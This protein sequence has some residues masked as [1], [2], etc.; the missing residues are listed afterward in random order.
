M[1]P[2]MT[3]ELWRLAW[4][5]MLRNLLNCSC[6]RLTLAVVGHYDHN[7]AHYDGAGLG[8]MLSNITGLSV[9]LGINMG[10]STMCAQAYGAGRS[11]NENWLHLRR[12]CFFL[13]CVFVWSAATA[14]FADNILVAFGQP[15][16][17]AT[18]S[19]QFAQINLVGV[20]FF[21]LSSALQTICDGLQNTKPGL[22]SMAVASICQIGICVALVNPNVG[23]VGFLGMAMARSAA[24]VIQLVVLVVLIKMQHLA[25]MV[26]QRSSNR[27]DQV[28]VFDSEA[29]RAYVVVTLP[30]AIIWWLEWWSFEGLTV[31]VG[32]LPNAVVTL[33]AH[34]TMFNVI[35]TTY[36]IF[37][38][39]GIA[40]CAMTGKRIGQGR[41]NE[42]P[43]MCLLASALAVFFIAVVLCTLYFLR[44]Q[45]GQ[46]FSNNP[47]IIESVKRNM[48]GGCFSV[49]G[50]AFLMTLGGACRGA[51]RQRLVALSTLVG[52]GIGLPLAWVLG[53]HQHWPT[54]LF[55]VWIG[56]AA[57]LAFAA[58]CTVA[59]VSMIDW[60]TVTKAVPRMRS[61][62]GSGDVSGDGK[63][64]RLLSPLTTSDNEDDA[65]NRH[66]VNAHIYE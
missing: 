38:G 21:W 20:P 34:G 35:V 45:I 47:D 14:Y 37:Q 63:S 44:E 48:L 58:S 46:L 3:W 55:G 18:A 61:N 4:P 25:P 51:N 31:M 7:T 52:Y 24:G 17:V 60:S 57:A 50:Y 64:D 28:P 41:G 53:Y 13:S 40:L 32:L 42:I 19:A 26:W 1:A 23:N 36:Q 29:L 6:D 9:G 2:S 5:A 49:P 10:L 33:G 59:I 56:N 43:R 66:S 62:T 39:L 54:P 8:K 65:D 16:D 30:S 22:Y 27:A 12:C 15:R 11:K